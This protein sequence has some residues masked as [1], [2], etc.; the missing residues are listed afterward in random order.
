MQPEGQ[1]LHVGPKYPGAHDSQ[2][3]PLNPVGH[4]HVPEAEQTPLPE[5]GGEHA[6]DCKFRRESEPEAVSGSWLTSGIE[7]QTM[8]RLLLPAETSAQTFPESANDDALNVDA[9]AIG[10][11]GRPV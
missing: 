10:E 1:A 3:V 9:F 4:V 8:T 6:V 7:F 2:E 11:S 5:Q